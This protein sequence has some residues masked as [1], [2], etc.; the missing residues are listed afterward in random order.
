MEAEADHHS[1][2]EGKSTAKLHKSTAEEVW[3]LLEDFFSIHNWLPSIDACYKVEGGVEGQHG[4]VR[5]CAATLPPQT[6]GGDAVVNWCHEKLIAIDPID[7]CLVYEVLDNNMG[8]KSY[9]STLKVIEMK[10][11]DELNGCQIEWSFLA[12]PVEGLS[13]EDMVAYLDI[14]LQGM[15]HNIEKALES[16]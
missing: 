13:Y 16:S 12:D 8:F 4:L 7:K 11:G 15:A 5:Y 9:R 10:G 14:S 3:P 2:W 6:D 1:K